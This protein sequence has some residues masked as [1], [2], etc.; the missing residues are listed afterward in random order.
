[1]QAL[2]L[3][4]ISWQFG[5]IRAR[6][7]EGQ[8]QYAKDTFQ[9]KPPFQDNIRRNGKIEV[10]AKIIGTF[11]KFGGIRPPAPETI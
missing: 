2:A 10:I 3:G 11:I 1:M 4:N 7:L 8:K 6:D 9:S 5:C